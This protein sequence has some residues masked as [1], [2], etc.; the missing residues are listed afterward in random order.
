MRYQD[1]SVSLSES[2]PVWPGDEPFRRLETASLGDG[3]GCNVSAL[4]MSAHTGTHVDAPFHFIQHGIKVDEI[5]LDTLVGAAWVCVVPDSIQV[6][7]VD[8][9]E[10]EGI[11][12]GTLRLLLATSNSALWASQGGQMIED[13]VSLSEDAAGWLVGRGVLLVGIDYLSVDPFFSDH[14]SHTLLLSAGIV[15]VEALDLRGVPSGPCRLWCLPLRVVG[16]DGAPAR[17]VLGWEDE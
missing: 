9:L 16:G 8:L 7:T 12:E 10:A 5:P 1:V 13:Y 14:P 6:V 3:D 15:I 4:S 11:P 17:A 2:T